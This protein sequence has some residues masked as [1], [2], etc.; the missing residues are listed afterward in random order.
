MGVTTLPDGIYIMGGYDTDLRTL[1][2]KTYRMEIDNETASVKLHEASDMKVARH[3]HHAVTTY[4]SSYAIYALGGITSNQQQTPLVEKYSVGSEKWEMV[5]P[6]KSVG[7]EM[8]MAVCFTTVMDSEARV[9]A[10]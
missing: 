2:K 6:L 3:S 9:E 7:G 4:G 10:S 8:S 5:A 1:S